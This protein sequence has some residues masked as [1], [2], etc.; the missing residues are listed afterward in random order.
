MRIWIGIYFLFMLFFVTQAPIEKAHNWRQTLTNTIA[1]NYANAETT[2]LEPKIDHA[3][4]RDG[5]IGSEFPIY[6]FTIAKMM[7]WFG[8]QHWYGRLINLIFTCLGIWCFYLI[9][10]RLFD[11]DAAL[12]AGIFLLF[13]VWFNFG[14]KI[15][16]DTL[17][18]SLVIMGIYQAIRFL[19]K[20]KWIT[21]V[22]A[23]VLIS[24]G[25]LIKIPAAVILAPFGLML[26]VRSWPS[27]RRIIVAALCILTIIPVYSW[28]FRWVPVLNTHGFELYFPRTI[29]E[30]WREIAVLWKETIN[31]FVFHSFYSF[32][33]FAI[34]F[35]ALVFIIIK[36]NWRAL[37]IFLAAF[38]VFSYFI[39][40]TG[41]TFP[42]HSYYMI[43]FAPIMAMVAGIGMASFPYKKFIPYIL[44]IFC[45]ESFA[46]QQDDLRIR[47][48]DRSFLELEAIADSIDSREAKV[49]CNGGVSPTVMYFLNRRGWTQEDHE[50]TNEFL[51]S[52]VPDGAQY[53][54]IYQSDFEPSGPAFSEKIFENDFLRVYKNP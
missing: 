33:G 19:D 25:M 12:Y 20:A 8:F 7:Q 29:S 26:F 35:A 31:N 17:S 13:S 23:F 22:L 39:L 21:A 4:K 50:L 9:V 49:V 6:N 27:Q 32:V 44:L 42:L 3:G 48:A 52:I 15:M 24:L 37:L 30:G 54:Y 5:I 2:F 53:L 51:E 18:L 47:E 38:A 10:K 11:A 40:K 16:P 1:R 41:L 14:R 34:F 36:K 45:G 28:Y 46:N 43:P